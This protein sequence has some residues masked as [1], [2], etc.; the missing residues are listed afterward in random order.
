MALYGRDRR[1]IEAD[2]TQATDHPIRKLIV[3]LFTR[4]T[5]RPLDCESVSADLIETFPHVDPDDAAPPRIVYH[6]AVLKDAQ[7]LPT[8]R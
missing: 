7:L 5:W 4:D 8:G 6:V 1:R 3:R 2:Q